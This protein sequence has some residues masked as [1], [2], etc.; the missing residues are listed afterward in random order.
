[1]KNNYKIS[2]LKIFSAEAGDVLHAMKKSD[3]GYNG[4]GEAYFSSINYGK[5]KA[6]KRHRQMTCNFIVPVGK[7]LVVLVDNSDDANKYNEI[8]LS[9]DNY[10]RLTISP[11]TWVG[12]QGISEGSSLLLNIADISH[13]PDETDMKDTEQYNYEWSKYI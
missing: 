8:I 3:E 6:W 13:N 9:K 2:K 7:I 4:F 5:I 1:M 11:M 10:V 12:F